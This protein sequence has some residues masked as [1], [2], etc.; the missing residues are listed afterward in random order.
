MLSDRL[1]GLSTPFPGFIE[2]LENMELIDVSAFNSLSGIQ[3]DGIL[4][5]PVNDGLSTPFPGF[6][7]PPQPRLPRHPVTFNSLSGI[8]QP[9]IELALSIII[10]QLPFRDSQGTTPVPEIKLILSTPFPGFKDHLAL[11]QESE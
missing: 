7:N 4:R 8:P 5:R 11:V 1:G 9:L 6:E 3:G 2:A 10:F